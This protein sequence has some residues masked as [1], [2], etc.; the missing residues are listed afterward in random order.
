MF[1]QDS[2]ILTEMEILFMPSARLRRTQ[3]SI[4]RSGGP[5]GPLV[6]GRAGSCAPLLNPVHTA[7]HRHTLQQA[8]AHAHST[9]SQQCLT[10]TTSHERS[11]NS[12]TAARFTDR[13]APRTN[14]KRQSVKNA[15]RPR[16][17]RESAVGEVGAAEVPKI[18]DHEE[19]VSDV[20]GGME[21]TSVLPSSEN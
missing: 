20:R 14:T 21:E 11:L 16:V 12:T 6:H 13:S 8:H 5:P 19:R 4:P 17:R 1:Q 9:R 3:P 15:H 7:L 18:G 2:H 10:A